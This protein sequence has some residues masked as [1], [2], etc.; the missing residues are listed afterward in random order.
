MFVLD[1]AVDYLSCKKAENIYW[2]QTKAKRCK[3]NQTS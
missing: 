3:D 1:L 2:A